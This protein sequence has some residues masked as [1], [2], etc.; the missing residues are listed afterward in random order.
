VGR[1]WLALARLDHSDQA[2]VALQRAITLAEQV[3][4]FESAGVSALSV[5]EVLGANLSNKEVSATIDHAGVLLEKTQDVTTLRRLATAF[6]FLFLTR[7]IPAP[8]DWEGFSFKEAV[9]RY[10]ARLIRLA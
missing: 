10:E 1:F 3:G 7:A 5:L 2:L 9:R 8:P 4:D 6:R